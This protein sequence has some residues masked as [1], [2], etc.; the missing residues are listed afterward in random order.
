MFRRD[1]L[2]KAVVSAAALTTGCGKSQPSTSLGGAQPLI[3]AHCHVFNASDLPAARFIRQVV[4]E[5]FPKQAA[6]RL[7]GIR[8]PDVAD[9]FIELLLRLLGADK[10]PDAE[11]EIAYL[12]TGQG[13][14]T[15][16][17][18]LPNAR[19]AAIEDT[20]QFLREVDSRMRG[21]GA[22][23]VGST[24]AI[25][26]AAIKRG[27]QKFLDFFVGPVL[28]TRGLDASPMSVA[29]ARAVSRDAFANRGAIT[30]Y[31]NWF[32]LFRLYRHALVDRL[33]ADAKRQGFTAELLT[34][35]LVDYD[36]WLFED[37]TKT[38]L[39]KQMEV[40]DYISRR[41]DR[42]A[43]HGYIGFD[44]L[45]EVAYRARAK[46]ATVSSLATARRAL[47]EHGFIGVKLYPPMGFRA[48][49]NRG[50]YPQRTV[51][52]LGFRPDRQ[53]DEALNDLYALCVELDAPILAHGY[54]SNGSGPEYADRGDPAYWLPVFNKHPDLSV[55]LAHFGRFDARSRGREKLSLPDGSW[56]WALGEFIRANP[57]RRVFADISYFSEALSGKP[58]VRFPLANSFK[59]WT[60]EFDPKAEHLIF[61]TDWIMLGQEEGY[62]HYLESVNSFLRHDCGFDDEICE[63]IFRSNAMQFLPLQRGSKGRRRLLAWYARTAVDPS[64]LPVA[65]SGVLA[66]LF[67]ESR[68]R[69]GTTGA[70]VP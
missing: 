12:K 36:E 15:S 51:D 60:A 42:P 31:L 33:I 63:R 29:E 40:M 38:P 47:T 58:E 2:K 55:C 19:L 67:R 44:P 28:Q 68:G 4:F 21:S 23:T 61:G 37:V 69:F 24:A 46:G 8:D 30:R 59:R 5:D 65:K 18:S 10:A 26:R 20:A 25:A 22:G 7:M 6:D 48:S 70:T 54:S 56:E 32:S 16:A 9:R 3:D 50:P 52:R 62:E 64:R 27:D 14:R 1:F 66:G 53:L 45:R 11:A 13:R 17:E 34:P 57:R 35:A 49:G 41:A 43:V 39:A